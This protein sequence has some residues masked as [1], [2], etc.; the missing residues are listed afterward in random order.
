MNGPWQV[1][2]FRYDPGELCGVRDRERTF[3]RVVFHIQRCAVLGE[4]RNHIV[5][6]RSSGDVEDGLVFSRTH[7]LSRAL[8]ISRFLGDPYIGGI[9][10]GIS[11]VVKPFHVGPCETSMRTIIRSLAL[12][13]ADSANDHP[14][15]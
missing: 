8:R 3:A 7:Q 13:A 10:E 4:E 9:V 14:G 15:G 12:V 6:P 5:C 1:R 2:F 11:G